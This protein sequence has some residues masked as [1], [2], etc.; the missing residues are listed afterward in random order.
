MSLPTI[1]ITGPTKIADINNDRR[2]KDGSVPEGTFWYK[3]VIWHYSQMMGG[4]SH[5]FVVELADAGEEGTYAR[6]I[7]PYELSEFEQI[8]DFG[9]HCHGFTTDRVVLIRGKKPE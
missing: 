2:G 4:E 3:G 8:F 5:S 7:K 1:S 9:G 6:P